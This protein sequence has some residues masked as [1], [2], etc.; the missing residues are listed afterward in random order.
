[1]D[2]KGDQYRAIAGDFVVGMAQT[3]GVGGIVVDGVIRDLTGIAI[4]QKVLIKA[5]K[6][7]KKDQDREEKISGN[8]NAIIRHLDELLSD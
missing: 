5:T 3:L 8:R 4:E 1:M 2:A 6:K 7:L